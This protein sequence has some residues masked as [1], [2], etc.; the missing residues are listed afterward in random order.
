MR[1]RWNPAR[2]SVGLGLAVWA[3]LFW[4]LLGSGR[5]ALYLSSRVAW[6]IP[7]GAVVLTLV[8]VG[9][10]AT[11]RS[12]VQDALGI[13]QALSL[14][15]IVLP[16]VAVLMFR[17]FTFGSAFVSTQSLTRGFVSGGAD[18]SSGPVTLAA[19]ASA[20]WSKDGQRA[21]VERAGSSVSFEGFVDL[22]DGMPADEFMLSRFMVS[23]CA[24]D[25]I[26]ISVR[27]VGAPPA[28][29]KPDQWVR[30][31]GTIYPVGSQVVVDAS[32]IVPI[33]QPENPYLNP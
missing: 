5:W 17:P 1:R 2:V 18:L 4:Y 23:C 7:A 15:A 3:A 27:V 8:A 24:A 13:R 26:G 16:A 25:A 33:P 28:K 11:A 22:R 32:N 14:G 10:L 29:F 9:R 31:E 21:L 20:Q 12:T 6:V 19:V 30:V